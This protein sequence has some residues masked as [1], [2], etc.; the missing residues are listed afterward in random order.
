VRF[1]IYEATSEV[2]RGGMGTVYRA[3]SAAGEDVAIKVLAGMGE[4]NRARFDRER[5]LL[6]AFTVEDGFVPVL[7]D[8]IDAHGHPYI[9]M[10]FVAGGTLRDRLLK[11]PLGIDETV[12]L[13]RSLAAAL[14]RAHERGIVHRDLKPENVLF[15]ADG[16]P[17]VADL[18]IGKHFDRQAPGASQSVNL[19]LP[20]EVRGTVGYMAPE[21]AADASSAGPE[22][23]VFALGSILYECLAGAQAFPANNLME[24]YARTSEG[25]RPLSHARPDAPG[26]LVTAVHGAL[27]LDPDARIADGA[28]LF[29]ALA[30]GRTSR[31]PLVLLLLAI[32]AVLAGGI[33]VAAR[34]R[35]VPPPPPPPVLPPPPPAPRLPAWFLALDPRPALPDFLVPSETKGEYVSRED[36]SVFVYVPE[37]RCKLGSPADDV[38]AEEVETPVYEVVLSP[39]FIGKYKVT[40]DQFARFVGAYDYITRAEGSLPP[41]PTGNS[42]TW[43]GPHTTELALGT[44][45]SPAEESASWKLPIGRQGPKALGD[46]P[47]LQVQLEDALA[48][49]TWA[50]ATLP[51]E[52]QWECAARW[53]PATGKVRRFPWGDD[54]P[55]E[56]RARFFRTGVSDERPPSLLKIGPAREA[57]NVS[58]VGAVQMAGNARD[59]V[60]DDASPDHSWL[61][62]RDPPAR[63]PVFRREGAELPHVAKGGSVWESAQQ[64]RSAYRKGIYGSDDRTSFRLAIP[65][66]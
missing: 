22:A 58:P 23:D 56:K 13:G 33:A 7:D 2:G 24:Y 63:D 53:D 14:A 55:D 48:Y 15:T 36:D 9:V 41:V 10:P 66:R 62:G 64:I 38:D 1:G 28:A 57:T 47:V 29:E 5:R 40:T 42:F 19:S 54:P 61:A 25:A 17:L 59:L 16:R 60:L 44:L 4:Q 31:A 12:A 11:G 21:Q 18:G 20:G 49:A 43:P 46:R 27:A 8:G 26:W 37:A 30:A 6:R 51:S 65:A 32:V 52:A 35:E 39:F 50:K 45:A 3:R 34:K